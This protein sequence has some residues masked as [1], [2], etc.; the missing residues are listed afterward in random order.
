M[1]MMP[2]SVNRSEVVSNT[3]KPLKKMKFACTRY[4]SSISTENDSSSLFTK[5]AF[6]CT[7]EVNKAHYNKLRE[8]KYFFSLLSKRSR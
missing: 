3:F 1:T 7:S 6:K 8:E 5:L 2:M 4:F